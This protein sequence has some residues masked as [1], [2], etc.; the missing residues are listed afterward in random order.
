MVRDSYSVCNSLVCI[1]CMVIEVGLCALLR[2]QEVRDSY[3]VRDSYSVCNS[4]VCIK[5]MVIEVGLCGFCGRE[6]FVTHMWFVN[7]IV[8]VT[9]SYHMYGDR[10]R[11]VRALV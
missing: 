5:C 4:F 2:E 11:S 3:V 9:H 1:K 7:H 6:K 10:S 8:C